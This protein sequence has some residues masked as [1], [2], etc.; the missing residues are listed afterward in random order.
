MNSLK[1]AYILPVYW[2]AIG[3]CEIHTHELVKRLSEKHQIKVITQINNQDDKLK[4]EL[5]FAAILQA[6]K[7]V[8]KYLD[9]KAEVYRI[10]LHPLQKAFLFPLARVQSTRVP[11]SVRDPLVIL[12]SKF[13]EKKLMKFVADCNLIHCVHGGVSY[14]GYA[15]L[16]VARK[17]Q[18]PFVYTPVPHFYYREGHAEMK[19]APRGWMNRFWFNICREADALITM[20]DFEKKFFVKRGIP[21]KN[22]YHVGVGPVL[23][24]N[25]NGLEFRKK[26][27]VDE[28]YMVLF[29]GRNVEYKGIEEIL[30]AARKVWQ[31]Y[32]DVCFC[33]IGPQEGR[34]KQIFARH[35]DYRIVTTGSVDLSEKTSALMACDILCMP[36][37]QE[38]L[39]GVFIE[40]WMY[41]KPIIGG[42][43]PPIRELTGNG[44]GGFL[45][46]PNPEEIAHRIINLLEDRNLRQDMG[47]WGKEKVLAD[48]TWEKISGKLENIYTQ[49]AA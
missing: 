8:T 48:Y 9:H 36:S 18:I 30:L 2:P 33:F 19:F 11:G 44:K 43:I 38:S 23:S 29:L 24:N 40:A 15:A 45:V 12:L 6:P 32:P 22:I 16:K 37:L 17:K 47:K 3:G 35:R 21:A 20:T 39:G 41:E 46:N 25:G 34:V 28:K 26:Y 27:H 14:L 49:L 4:R 31:R 42:T 1:I 13:F 5:W 10:P 7:K